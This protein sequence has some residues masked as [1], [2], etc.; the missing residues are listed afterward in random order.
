MVGRK[1]YQ[2]VI[3][4]LVVP[5]ILLVG[6][7]SAHTIFRCIYDNVERTACCC[8]ND[9]S[10]PSTEPTVEQACCCDIE[11]KAAATA[12]ERQAQTERQETTKLRPALLVAFAALAAPR[13]VAAVPR[14]S[15]A[16]EHPPAG[17]P[18]VLL[19]CSF[20]I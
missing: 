10:E 14:P 8:P 2:R 4:A 13:Q 20:L 17:P 15:I 11:T 18:L 6:T 5:L 12:V 9:S 19:K 1:A 7:G 16:C 3:A